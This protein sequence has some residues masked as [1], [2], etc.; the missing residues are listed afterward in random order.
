MTDVRLKHLLAVRWFHWINFPVLFLMIWSGILIY[1]ANDVYHVGGFHFFP[2]WFYRT[3]HVDHQLAAGMALHFLFMWIFTING[4]LYFA[5]T[6]VS[7]EWKFL[8]PRSRRAFRDAFDVMLYDL[9][10]KKQLPPQEKYNAAQQITY[11]A[12]A[13]M[14]V[15]SVLTGLAIYKPTQLAWLATLFGGYEAARFIHF[16]LTIG[17]VVFFIIHI[18]QVIRAGWQN[19]Q[20]MITGYELERAPGTLPGV[21]HE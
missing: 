7:G 13:L 14:G 11:T 16:A 4:V 5:Y 1:W 3:F 2:D 15:G 9:H 6:I 20:S 8:V 21:P 18:L 12:I 10:L 19:F 17:Y